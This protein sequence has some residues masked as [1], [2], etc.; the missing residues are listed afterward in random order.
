MIACLGNIVC[1]RHFQRKDHSIVKLS[2][3]LTGANSK[4]SKGNNQGLEL[5]R[6]ASVVGVE[7]D[8]YVF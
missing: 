6:F 4:Y 7:V 5:S 8:F 1:Q 3:F 2:D